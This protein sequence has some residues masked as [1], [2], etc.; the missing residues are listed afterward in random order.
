MN[1]NRQKMSKKAR[2]ANFVNKRYRCDN[3]HVLL[4]FFFRQNVN[5][6]VKNF[7]KT[8][9]NWVICFLETLW[10]KSDFENVNFGLRNLVFL[11]NLLIDTYWKWLKEVHIQFVHKIYHPKSW[12]LSF[13]I[14]IHEIWDHVL[15]LVKNGSKS[16]RINSKIDVSLKTSF[17]SVTQICE[18]IAEVYSNYFCAINKIHMFFFFSKNF[19]FY[20]TTVQ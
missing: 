6:S 5:K 14:W 4:S 17:I 1:E 10:K 15:R 2:M 18:G 20:W 19:G 12:K 3:Y 8:P 9:E 7:V 11:A 16:L 13:N